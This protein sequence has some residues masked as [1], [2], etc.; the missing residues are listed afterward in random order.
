VPDGRNLAAFN[1]AQPHI[2]RV[3]DYLLGGKDNFAADRAVADLIIAS[4]PP[5][6]VRVRAQRDLLGRVVRFLVGEAGIRQL[7]D[8]GSGL[9]TADNVH[10]I[11]HRIEPA[12]KVVYV[13]N[14]QKAIVAD[15]GEGHGKHRRA[16]VCPGINR[17]T[18]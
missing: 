2:A 17:L 15:R 12:T 9:P 14:D 10:Q 3:Y 4:M 13:D 16:S 6:Q 1:A 7:L 8:I 11:A 5:V 18:G